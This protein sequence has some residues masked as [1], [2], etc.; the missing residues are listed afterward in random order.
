MENREFMDFPS[1]VGSVTMWFNYLF[2]FSFFFPGRE[3]HCWESQFIKWIFLGTN[4]IKCLKVWTGHEGVKM[5]K[6][7]SKSSADRRLCGPIIIKIKKQR[8]NQGEKKNLQ[9]HA[10]T[11]FKKMEKQEF[12]GTLALGKKTQMSLLVFLFSYLIYFH[13]DCVLYHFKPAPISHRKSALVQQFPPA[14]GWNEELG[15]GDLQKTWE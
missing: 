1:P 13:F 4:F 9:L 15:D 6:G 12:C 3:S 10:Q 2:F 8:W 7:D 11:W 14:W 5:L